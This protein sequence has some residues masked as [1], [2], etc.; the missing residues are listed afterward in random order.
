MAEDAAQVSLVD[1]DRNKEIC[2]EMAQILDT[3]FGTYLSIQ[4]IRASFV[5]SL[6]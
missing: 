4:T 2:E 6:R 3:Q 1:A 5:T